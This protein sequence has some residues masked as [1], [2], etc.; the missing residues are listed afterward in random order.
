MEF[1]L[2]LKEYIVKYNTWYSDLVCWTWAPCG[3]D[4][5]VE[6]LPVDDGLGYLVKPLVCRGLSVAKSP[7]QYLLVDGSITR[8]RDN[9]WVDCTACQDFVQFQQTGCQ[10]AADTVC[11][12]VTECDSRFV[13]VV[14]LTAPDVIVWPTIARMILNGLDIY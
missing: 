11:R 4:E 7:N 13:V 9:V 5:Y 8:D 1:F 6:Q 2:P 3:A 14:P 10:P 12:A